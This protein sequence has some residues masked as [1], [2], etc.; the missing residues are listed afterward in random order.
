[1]IASLIEYYDRLLAVGDERVAPEGKSWQSVGYAVV[2]ELDGTLFEIEDRRQ[3]VYPAATKANPNPKSYRANRK[4]ILPGLG[5]RT[6]GISANLLW[7]KAEYLFAYS[8]GRP[9]EAFTAFREKH[10]ALEKEISASEFSAVCRFVEK[11]KPGS[12]KKQQ[13]DLIDRCGMCSGIFQIR[14]Q[15]HYVHELPEVEVYLQRERA[16][17]EADNRP[18]VQSSVSGKW[19]KPTL[20]HQLQVKGVKGANTKG[21]A[22]ISYNFRATESYEMEHAGHAPMSESESFKMHSALNVLTST[23][24]VYIDDTTLLYWTDAPPAKASLAE[25]LLGFALG[26]KAEDDSLKAQLNSALRAIAKGGMPASDESGTRF[27]LLGL[28]GAKGRISVRFFHQ[29]TF[30]ELYERIR[31]HFSALKTE[32]MYEL[33]PEFPN[34]WDLLKATVRKGKNGQKA[35]PIASGM[36]DDLARAIF[37]GT[38]YPQ[39]IYA[40]VLRRVQVEGKV[41]Y[42]RAAIIN[43]V[44][45]KN[46]KM[47]NDQI[48][49]AASFWLGKL[50]ALHINVQARATGNTTSN[51]FGAAVATPATVFPRL[52]RMSHVYLDKLRRDGSEGLAYTFERQIAELR[53]QIGE[54]PIRLTLREQGLFDAGYYRQ[55]HTM[56]QARQVRI[57][58]K[59]AKKLA[60]AAEQEAA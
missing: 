2:L 9:G 5:G 31:E 46:Y 3:E 43:A 17:A 36:A 8:G 56:E 7:D 55:L 57:A 59:A 20:K 4:M 6:S 51:I 50:L 35:D 26:K 34:I 48:E 38:D 23:Q 30:G 41:G 27:W 54:Y 37:E 28:K 42:L 32:R 49:T 15:Q 19:V 18:L 39:S 52:A 25:Q 40:A 12:L 24:R 1:M 14:G 60:A 10:L 58:E 53:S 22:L 13:K 44:L 21:A 16:A 45:K 11:W 29:S 33:E 47:S